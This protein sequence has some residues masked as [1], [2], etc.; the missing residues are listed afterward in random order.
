MLVSEK[1]KFYGRKNNFY[2]ERGI[3]LNNQNRPSVPSEVKRQLRKEAGYGCCKCGFPI[4]DYQHIIE[5]SVEQHFRPED[6]MLLCPNCHREATLGV[7]NEKEQRYYKLNPYNVKR[8]YVDGQ[9]FVKQQ[10]LV[11]STGSVELANDG[12]LLAVDKEPL[13]VINSNQNGQL[14]LTLSLYDS[15]DNLLVEIEKNEW[16][17]GDPSVWDFEYKYQWLKLWRKKRG[18]SL[19]IDARTVPLNIKA[20]IW[21]KRQNFKLSKKGLYFNGV[22]KNAS[23]VNLCLVGM[24]LN[25]DIKKKEFQIVPD[26]K[27]GRGVLVSQPDVKKRIEQ[28]LEALQK[29]KMKSIR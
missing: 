26:E 1:A 21:R 19:E 8:G 15:E 17:T 6:M 22:V 28:G 23:I 11:I 29:L 14:E 25:A 3:E 27:L 5:Y 7:M 20:E 16:I 18:I 24:Y 9:L 10:G 4:F 13:L 12:F 2:K